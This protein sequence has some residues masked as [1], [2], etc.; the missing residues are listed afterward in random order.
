MTAGKGR[1]ADDETGAETHDLELRSARLGAGLGKTNTAAPQRVKAE[2][3]TV[4]DVWLR[5]KGDAAARGVKVI[6]TDAK[7]D[8]PTTSGTPLSPAPATPP[9]P[10][11]AS[12]SPGRRPGPWSHALAMAVGSLLVAILLG[13]LKGEPWADAVIDWVLAIVLLVCTLAVH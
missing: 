10:P 9:S 3:Q 5:L 2:G 11:S 8:E 12:A 1:P 13:K 4:I 6:V 7:A